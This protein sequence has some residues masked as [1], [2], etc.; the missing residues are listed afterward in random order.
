MPM[1]P[2]PPAQQLHMHGG[3]G[4]P[5]PFFSQ[6]FCA[7]AGQLCSQPAMY[8]PQQQYGMPQQCIMDPALP[9]FMQGMAQPGGSIHP[10]QW[11]QQA[12]CYPQPAGA[13][14]A[15]PPLCG[16]AG[17]VSGATSASRKSF[18]ALSA[19]EVNELKTKLVKTDIVPFINRLWRKAYRRGEIFRRLHGFWASGSR[20]QLVADIAAGDSALLEAD[21]WLADAIGSCLDRSAAA[22]ELFFRRP[23][24]NDLYAEAQGVTT[25]LRIAALARHE[26]GA[27]MTQAE[28]AFDDSKPLFMGMGNDEALL[29]VTQIAS[30]FGMLSDRCRNTL[31]VYRAIADKLPAE[32]LL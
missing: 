30:E 7:S 21:T 22:V 19:A 10:A 31:D 23:E 13:Y 11:E 24:S 14:G 20:S 6:P 2:V 29:A 1:Q 17:T 12:Y 18:K 32:R 8:S 5:Q 15:I 28:Q 3:C 25:L 27:A 9:P 26:P 16:G 4:A